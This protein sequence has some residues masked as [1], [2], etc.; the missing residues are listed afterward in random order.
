MNRK[1]L[2]ALKKSIKHWERNVLAKTPGKTSTGNEQCALCALFL[3]QSES[4]QGCPVALKTGKPYCYGSP[5]EKAACERN[6]WYFRLGNL[7]AKERWHLAAKAELAFL[8][9]LLP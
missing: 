8:R 7:K 3:N 9:S 2:S 4:C 5:Y 1:T 6:F